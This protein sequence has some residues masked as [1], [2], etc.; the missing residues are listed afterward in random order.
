MM[1]Y[2]YHFHLIIF[3]VAI[4][5]SS[6]KL[7]NGKVDFRIVQAVNALEKLELSIAVP[8]LLVKQTGTIA[9]FDVIVRSNITNEALEIGILPMSFNGNF[10]TARV[11]M[12]QL[13]QLSNSNAVAFI[14]APKMRYPTMNL[15]LPEMKVDKVHAGLV[16]STVYKGK[17]VIVGVIDSGID[18]KHQDFR[19]DT[20]TTKSRILF[21]WDQT[22]DRAGI[23]PTGFNYGAEYTQAQINNELDGTPA[24]VVLEA[25]VNG[26][27]THVAGTAAGDGSA[28]NGLYKGVAPEADLII[29]KGGD[30]GFSTTN[31]INGISYIR[32]KAVA[33]G[34]LF[35]INM[36][37]GGHDGSHDGIQAEEVTVNTELNGKTG[38]QIAIAAGNEG[39]DLIHADGT[40]AQG[41]SKSIVF[42]IPAYTPT[43]GTE[44]DAV[45]FSMWYKGGDSLTVALKTPNNTTV[46]AT[47]GQLQTVVTA[48]GFVQI[49]NA[50]NGVN[51]SNNSKEC[52]ITVVDFNGSVEPVSGAW[53]ITVTGTT[54]TQGGTFDIWLAGSTISGN[55]GEPVEITT[56]ASQTKL[57]GMPATAEKGITVGAYVTKWSWAAVGGNFSY[58]GTS[59]VGD[60]STFSSMGPTRDGRQ[61]PD[62]SAPGQG[63]ASTLSSA[64]SHGDQVTLNG[65]KYYITQGTSMATPHVAGLIALILQA[66]PT[67]TSDAIRTALKSTARK[68]AFTGGSASVQWGSGKVDAQA[69]LQNLLSVQLES[70]NIPKSFSLH[71]NYPNP[72]NPS[73]KISFSI[74]KDGFVTLKIYSILGEEIAILVDEYIIAGEYS[75][76]FNASALSNGMYFYT[77]TFNNSSITKKMLLL[78]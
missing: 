76:N 58:N 20:D 16:N 34:K 30:G 27:G 64:S 31:I 60:F 2:L 59:R 39:S 13:I 29:V 21:L 38:R 26:H 12:D 3:V 10:Y 25:D 7:N 1:K 70:E 37:L 47:S 48:Q 5:L 67:V 77:V 4:G 40:L 57:V 56:G 17:N 36:S 46:T 73:T 43:A 72:F 55:G 33:A 22:D 75:T 32:Q 68:D 74:P 61:K 15:S 19:S 23:G 9:L 35:V 44:N 18:W 49:A 6:G 63:I 69:V 28:S 42:T 45:N 65:K 11:T 52:A 14:E 50:N 24:N 53:T 8:G 71:Q 54:V 51:S 78:K 62:I 41:G 66:K